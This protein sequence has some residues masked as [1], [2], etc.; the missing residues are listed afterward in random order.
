MTRKT[1]EAALET[2]STA[3]EEMASK[4]SN[5][6]FIQSVDSLLAE[7]AKLKDTSVNLCHAASV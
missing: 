2:A 1:M 7:I 6:E 5:V 3:L 4:E